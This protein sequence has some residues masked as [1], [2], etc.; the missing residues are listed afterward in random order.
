M[1][2]IFTLHINTNC[3]LIDFDF[4]IPIVSIGVKTNC[5]V[6]AR[7]ENAGQFSSETVM[8]IM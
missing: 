4:N 8:E 7:R 5:G 2:G 6:H 1:Y 3:I